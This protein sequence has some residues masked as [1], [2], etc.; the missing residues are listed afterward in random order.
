[1]SA[2]WTICGRAAAPRIAR[3]RPT[4]SGPP[5]LRDVHAG[6]RRPRDPAL[7]PR[8][9]SPDLI[10]AMTALTDLVFTNGFTA[11]LSPIRTPTTGAARCVGRSSRVAPTPVKAPRV[12]AASQECAELIGLDPA[13]LGTED[14]ARVFGGNALVPGMDPYAMTYGG[15]SS[16]TGPASS[17]TAEP[18]PGRDRGPEG[19]DPWTSSSRALADPLL[20]SADGLAVLR[21]SVREFLC[22]EAMHHLGVP[23][24][25][26]LPG[27]H[28][29][30][31]PAG[32]VLRR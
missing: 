22:S 8:L 1:M 15:T 10:P 29:R 4:R 17:G 12:V 19:L 16:G 28:R 18:Q 24:T 13:E 21:S 11:E 25:R 26:A 9:H 2:R 20:R 31:G 6:R 5:H 14:F 27:E 3:S 23:T 32:H 30:A 7:P